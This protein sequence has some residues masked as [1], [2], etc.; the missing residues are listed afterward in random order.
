MK[1]TYLIFLYLL[2]IGP[3][4]MSGQEQASLDCTSYFSWEA[5]QG[6]DAT[7]KFTNLSAGDFNTWMWDFGDGFTSGVFHPIHTYSELGTYYVCLTVSDGV[8]CYDVYCDTVLVTPDCQAE[9]DFSYVPTTPPLVQFNDLSTGFPDS[10]LWD[11]GDGSTSGL[12]NPAHAYLEPG[13]YEVCLTIIHNDTAFHCTD[14]VCKIVIIPDSLNC[15]AA[16]TYDIDDD[17]PLKVHFNDQ[18]T[19]NITDWEWNFGD[20]HISTEQNPVHVFNDDGEYLVCLKVENNDSL[21]YCLHFICKTLVLY[22]TIQ[23]QAGFTAIADSSSQVMYRYSFVDESTGGPDNW[24]WN[25]GDGH[26]SYEQ[27][28]T[29]VYEKP[30][31]YSVCLDTWNSNNPGC[32]DTYCRL[33]K[34][35][36]Y[37]QLGGMAFIG[38]N[39]LNN[40]YPTGDTGIAILYRQRGQH[41]FVAVDTNT[42]HEL[43]YYWFSNM[44]QLG[45]IIHISLTPGSDHYADFIPSYFPGV[46]HWQLADVFMLDNN[47][48]E[49]NTSL[50]EVIAVEPG[51]GRISGRVISGRYSGQDVRS[52]YRDVPVFLTD[53]AGVPKSWTSTDEYGQFRFENLA[54]GTY[55]LHADVAGIWSQPETVILSEAFITNDTITIRMYE[56]S[57][58]S[59]EEPLTDAV[60]IGLLYP[61]PVKDEFTL[62]LNAAER[63]K[64]VACIYGTLGQAVYLQEYI[65]EEGS[66]T[67]VLPASRLHEGIYLISLQWPGQKQAMIKKF[68]KK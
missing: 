30:G 57:P 41:D 55:A 62:E 50:M 64:I 18:S 7:I 51:P 15:E 54:L 45:Y 56:S 67:L 36:E 58:F 9:F 60:S 34:T 4:I 42:F 26:L 24:T 22:D 47:M 10:W 31:I 61:N 29:H 14:S 6:E 19:G 20:G 11:F 39:P 32:S 21:E 59:V 17:N 48:F 28:P 5:V 68:I 33:I 3:L 13:S 43:G 16:Y 2:L 38:E 63:M 52:S 40:P 65:L 37:F 23:C 46:M 25:F 35:A 44:M 49:M 53:Q 12:Q 27:H 66:N 1:H 8:N